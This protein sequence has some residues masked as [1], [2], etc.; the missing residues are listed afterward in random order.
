MFDI[1]FWAGAVGIEK[2]QEQRL[3]IIKAKR[4][5]YID[6]LTIIY[7]KIICRYRSWQIIHVIVIPKYT[8]YGARYY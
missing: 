5:I 2:V 8:R 1:E 6:M 7:V 4:V 3:I